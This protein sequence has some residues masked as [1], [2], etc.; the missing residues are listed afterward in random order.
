M[1]PAVSKKLTKNTL[2]SNIR[3]LPTTE[4]A[5]ASFPG[6]LLFW[7]LLYYLL[8]LVIATSLKNTTANLKLSNLLHSWR[9]GCRATDFVS[10]GTIKDE[11]KVTVSKYFGLSL[12]NILRE[13]A[14]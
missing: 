2:S 13:P 7:S 12:R 8:S 14:L 10:R 9:Y 11:R 6:S 5:E 3:P 4:R 1:K